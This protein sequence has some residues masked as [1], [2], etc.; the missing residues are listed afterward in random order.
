MGQSELSEIEKFKLAV[1]SV[2]KVSDQEVEKHFLSL[3][4]TNDADLHEAIGVLHMHRPVIH[5]K[6]LSSYQKTAP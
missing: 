5:A 6:L 2:E 1:I 4:I 3:P